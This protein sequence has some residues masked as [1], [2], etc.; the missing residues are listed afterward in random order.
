MEQEWEGRL[1]VKSDLIAIPHPEPIFLGYSRRELPPRPDWTA[2][3]RVER[4]ASVT[5]CRGSRPE[6]WIERWDFND[7]GLYED[8]SHPSLAGVDQARY[9]LFS[10]EFYPLR[11]D[12]YGG[13]VEIPLADVFGATF[14]PPRRGTDGLVFIGF[15][16]VQRWVEGQ[17]GKVDANA[18]SGGFG[19][20]PLSCN[21]LA[22]EHP[23][24]RLCLIDRWEDAV[25]T[26]RRLGIQQPEPGCYYIFGVHGEPGV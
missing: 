8:P 4:I 19:C 14:V 20:S 17:P 21:G 5:E 15:D 1:R 7:A 6:G 2:D 3:P 23:V 13:T 11:F 18:F 16:I 25:S 24:N 10:H 12:R 22:P 9:H 26:A